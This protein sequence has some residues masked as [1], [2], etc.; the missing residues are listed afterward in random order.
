MA[1]HPDMVPAG[2]KDEATKAFQKLTDAYQ[3]R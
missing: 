3:V 2:K 1:K